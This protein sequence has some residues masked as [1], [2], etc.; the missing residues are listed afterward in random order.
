[1]RFLLV[2]AAIFLLLGL[3]LVSIDSADVRWLGFAPLLGAALC[4]LFAAVEAWR[5]RRFRSVR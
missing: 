3:W 2:L 4:L 1:M 5:R